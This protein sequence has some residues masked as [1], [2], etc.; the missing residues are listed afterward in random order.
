MLYIVGRWPFSDDVS[1][2]NPVLYLLHNILTADERGIPMN[3]TKGS[4]MMEPM[5]G[6]VQTLLEIMVGDKKAV[7]VEGMIIWKEHT[8]GH[9]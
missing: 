8:N 1:H 6:D 7:Q 5:D 9:L 2:E 4:R 3:V